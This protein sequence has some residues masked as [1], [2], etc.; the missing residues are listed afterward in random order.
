MAPPLK[1][2]PLQLKLGPQLQVKPLSIQPLRL[3]GVPSDE[4]PAQTLEADAEQRLLAAESAFMARQKAEAARVEAATDTEFW[5]A[6]YF[7]TR[8]QK[9]A[10]LRAMKLLEL[11]DKYLDGCEVARVLGVT[12]PQGPEWQQR[13][14]ESKRYLDFAMR[15]TPPPAK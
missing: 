9:E 4:A 1:V 15:P 3:P 14:K 13:V 5:C 8:E 2:S 11:G 6:L 10:F 7:Q 12:L